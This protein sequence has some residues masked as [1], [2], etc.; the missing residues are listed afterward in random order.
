MAKGAQWKI[1]YLFHL[2]MLRTGGVH[3]DI[4]AWGSNKLWFLY[5][6]FEPFFFYWPH[7]LRLHKQFENQTFSFIRFSWFLRRSRSTC[8]KQLRGFVALKDTA[9]VKRYNR[10]LNA[11]GYKTF[12]S[13]NCFEY[14]MNLIFSFKYLVNL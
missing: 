3:F 4:W 12:P 2:Q 1:R 9:R 7:F 5:T 10:T 8:A 13:K 6:H 14:F 11:P